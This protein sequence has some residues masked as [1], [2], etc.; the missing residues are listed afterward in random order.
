MKQFFDHWLMGAE[1][2]SWMVDGVPF[3][4]KGKE[5]PQ[6]KKAISDGS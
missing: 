5:G 4:Q 3:L 1:A 6:G 2:P